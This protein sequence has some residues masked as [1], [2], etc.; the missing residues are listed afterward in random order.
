VFTDQQRQA[1]DLSR[2]LSVTANAG[3]GK[4]T[5]LVRRLLN[6]LLDTSTR[7]SEIVAITYTEKAA[8]E[9]RREVANLLDAQLQQA[10][11][12]EERGR[13][14]QIRDQLPSAAIGTIHS[15][16]AQLLREHPVEADCDVAFTVLEGPDRDI[17]ENESL[18]EALEAMLRASQGDAER[19][20]CID[21]LRSMGRRN[22][23]SFVKQFLG[24]REELERMTREDGCLAPS[25][26]AEG[27]YTRARTAMFAYASKRIDEPGWRESLK[28]V[29]CLA[30]GKT[31]A[32]AANLLSHWNASWKPREK[33]D[34]YVQIVE[35]VLTQKN[36]FLK[37]VV[38]RGVESTE[39]AAAGIRFL[40]HSETMRELITSLKDLQAEQHDRMLFNQVQNL[41]AIYRRVLGIYQSRKAEQGFLDFEDLQLKTWELLQDSDVRRSIAA[42]YKFLMVDEFQD[43][44]HLQYDIV[45]ALT[46]SM[47]SRLFI[48]GDPKQSIY[49]FR[50]AEVEIFE[51]ARQEIAQ[52]K[53]NETGDDSVAPGASVTL[54]ESFRM[55]PA[56]AAFVNA[57]F[58]HAMSAEEGVGYDEIVV[59]RSFAEGE[60]GTVELLLHPQTVEGRPDGS[61]NSTDDD[62]VERECDLIARK[63]A[64]L[65][66][67]GFRIVDRGR[68]SQHR[69]FSFDDAA[70]LLRNRRHL[71]EIER[72]LSKHSIPYVLSGGIGFYQRQEVLDFVNYFR[73]LLNE[74]DDVALVGILRS[75]FFA[76]SDAELFE[77]S[78]QT[79]VGN[80]FWKKVQ[81]YV[82][83]VGRT[84][85]RIGHAR[86]I[87]QEDRQLA[88][89]LSI[90]LLVQRV[91]RQ[92]G[93]IGT[94]EGLPMG[95]SQHAANVKKLQRLAREFEGKGFSSLYDFVVRLESLISHDSREGQASAE[96]VQDCVQV[97]TIHAAKGLEFPVVMVPFAHEPFQSERQPFVDPEYGIGFSVSEES[98]LDAGAIKPP[99]C[100]FL[101]SRLQQKKHAEEKRVFYVACTRARDVLI[102]SGDISPY[103]PRA[104]SY[105]R[106]VFEGL[107]VTPDASM[108]TCRHIT[109][110]TSVKIARGSERGASVSVQ[111]F[112]L[113]V[114]VITDP[115]ELNIARSDQASSRHGSEARELFITPIAAKTR[116]QM[117][118]ATQIRTFL[119]CPSKY[120][121]RYELGLPETAA[122]FQVGDVE[123]DP[124][125]AFLSE[126]EGNITHHILQNVTNPHITPQE[127]ETQANSLM[128]TL[129]ARS[130]KNRAIAVDT[131]ATNV[132]NFIRSDFG[133]EVLHTPGSSRTEFSI[134][135]RHKTNFLT[136]TIDRMYR[137]RDGH[138]CILDYKTDRFSRDGFEAKSNLYYPQLA[139]YALLI[140]KLYEQACVRATLVFLRFP[141]APVHYEFN[142]RR[143]AD[144]SSIL[145]TVIEKIQTKSFDRSTELCG[146]CTYRSGN[147]CLV[148][149]SS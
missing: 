129:A 149:A 125:D 18:A 21:V 62:A 52:S 111:P 147:S 19:E 23:E 100:I 94:V 57:V 31:T 98:D 69:A 81:S 3:A 90:P 116:D 87:L 30:R 44:N 89:R 121:L 54:A 68:T 33:I 133:M 71:R 78:L 139:V 22:V 95:G 61:P 32:E 40:H 20:R 126:L 143:L 47:H 142:E 85:S 122:L 56:I 135:A 58:S 146:Q 99:F 42:R 27:L 91:F 24:H 138:M 6:I 63:I 131:I 115:S 15:F 86:S 29:L 37:S 14:E 118:T 102:I 112:E 127:I 1:L 7:V 45:R 66:Y 36:T 38:G 103:P 64:H 2:H 92:T 136:G 114:G 26:T 17:L 104:A 109:V 148:P 75:P 46:E 13:L 73:F 97:M 25:L 145:D 134:T 113:Q 117:Y 35:R 83:S 140:H 128:N 108:Q 93:W 48:V 70:I 82:P 72:A 9:L 28:R 80:G 65:K 50:H 55:L 132:L 120:Y 39:L 16:C 59:G 144:F 49:S 5:V 76:V 106:W 105:M 60:S 110:A 119:E 51:R 10:R 53:A 8:G 11:L 84:F 74:D 123:E 34:W 12:P 67:S 137:D 101:K 124:H 41:L 141:D 4:T 130:I 96:F 43:T 107:N 88:H 79:G 77:V